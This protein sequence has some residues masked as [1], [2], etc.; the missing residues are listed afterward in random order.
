MKIHKSKSFPG[1]LIDEGAQLEQ[2]RL[3]CAASCAHGVWGQ[4]K[5]L[6]LPLLPLA[7]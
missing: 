3:H 4:G 7:Q 1:E 5:R 6:G 2:R